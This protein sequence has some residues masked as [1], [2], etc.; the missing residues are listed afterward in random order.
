MNS[1]KK[2]VNFSKKIFCS[3]A[4]AQETPIFTAR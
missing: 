3:F 1:N 4:K 2:T